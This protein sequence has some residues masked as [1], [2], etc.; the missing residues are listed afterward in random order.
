MSSFTTLKTYQGL[1]IA[2]LK[3]LINGRDIYIWGSG[4]LGRIIKRSFDK[5]GLA[6]KSFCD[7]NPKLK[8]TLIDNVKVVNPR[9]IF[10]AVRLKQ[11]FII[12]ASEQYKDE[13]EKD[14]IKAK[15]IKK[16]DFLSY[17]HISRP[18]VAIDVAGRC[19]IRCV[20]C[21]RGNMENLRPEGY[22]TASV[23]EQVLN[24][25]LTELPLL[26]NIELFT[27]GEPFMNPELAEI[28]QMSEKSVPCTVAANL[29]IS[30][31][32]EDVVKSQ[33]SQMIIST[34]GYG[35]S[36]EINH[37]GASW[38]TFF[39]NIHL[40][41]ELIDK[42]NPKTQFTV[43]YHLYRNNQQE[44]LDNIHSLCSKLGLRCATSWAYLNPYDKILDYCEG[45]D[46]GSEAKGVV[47]ILQWDLNRALKLAKTEASKPCLCQRI[48]PIINWDLSVSLCHTY[49][50]PVI[51]KNFLE[52][53][54]KE[55]IKLRHNQQQCETCQKHGL[56]RLDI[57]VLLKNYPATNILESIII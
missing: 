48:F 50:G 12:I 16:E 8:M 40:L 45:R 39:D 46:I 18:E 47:D 28:I 34:S 9:D 4:H 57:E 52:L 53:P 51:A 19:N 35:K 20:S 1:S 32:L 15:L 41:K 29:Q 55:L 7:S 36:Y 5:N 2:E 6:V 24:K 10:D 31:K 56:H 3:T 42:Y 11:A 13:I 23:Y 14:C 27:W 30:D 25:L 37:F 26:T 49:Y 54:L 21:P 33:P 38:Q 22:M 43:L 44:D 17:I